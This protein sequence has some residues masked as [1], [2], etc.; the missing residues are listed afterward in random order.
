MPTSVAA[1]LTSLFLGLT[2]GAEAT[3]SRT[4]LPILKLAGAAPLAIEG[5]GFA[6]GEV[7]RLVAETRELRRTRTVIASVKGSLRIRFEL[8]LPRCA[9]LTVRATGSLGS[10]AVLH[11]S[12]C[13][14]P[15]P[16]QPG[17]GES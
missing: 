14:R 7:V 15:K 11:R 6:A 1:V 10:R 2:A 13:K 5:R 4:R 9:E 8:R 12:A 16:P 3:S 17:R